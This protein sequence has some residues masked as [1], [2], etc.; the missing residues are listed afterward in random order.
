MSKIK[1]LKKGFVKCEACDGTGD[2]KCDACEKC[3]R[4]SRNNCERCEGT[5]TVDW[6][7]NVLIAKDYYLDKRK[8][9]IEE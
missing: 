2:C 8:M 5:G 1:K 4:L 6:I 7:K 9:R 3:E